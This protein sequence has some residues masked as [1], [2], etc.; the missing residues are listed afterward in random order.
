MNNI[1]K[2]F[3]T[4]AILTF[5]YGVYFWG[6]PAAINIEKRID[7]FEKYLKDSTGYNISV[8]KP[9]IKMGLLP[10]VWFMAEDV[11]LLNNDKSKVFNMTHSAIKLNLLPLIFGKIQVANFSAD[12]I[13]AD[14]IYT[15]NSELKLGQYPLHKLPSSKMTLSKAYFRIGNY[16]IK[17][18][19]LKQNKQI[20][21]NG[22]YFNLDEFKRNKRIKLSTSSVLS[23]GNKNSQLMA[24]IDIK[25]P[26][27]KITEDQFK[28]KGTINNLDLSDFSDYAK[29]I[30]NSNITSLSGIIN[31]ITDTT[32]K[33]DKHKNIFTKLTIENLK[34]IQKETARSIYC[35]NKIEIKTDIDTIKNGLNIRNMKILSNGIDISLFGKAT[36]LESKTPYVDFNISINNSR[37]EKFIPLL[38]GEENLIEEVNFY[39]LKKNL[40]YGDINGNLKVKGKFNTPDINGKILV[41]EGYL[42]KPL[43]NNTEKAVIKLTFKDTKMYMDVIV[44]ASLKETVWVK[45]NVDLYGNKYADLYIKSTKNVDLNIAETVLNPLH[46]ILKF[47]LGPVPIMDIQGKGDIN[48]HVT[49]NRK[50]PHAW[51]TFNFRETTASFLDIKNMTLKNGE[52]KL[53]FDDQNTFFKTKKAF[54]NNKPVEVSGNCTLKGI[55][56]FK[57]SAKQQNLGDLLKIIKTSPM[58]IDIQKLLQPVTAAKGLT[59]ISINLTGTVIDVNNVVFNKNIF[60]KGTLDLYSNTVVL[61]GIPLSNVKGKINFNNL[62]TYFDL[63]SD[64]KNSQIKINGKADDKN[65]DVKIISD[66][67]VLKDAIDILKL[68]IPFKE[69]I[70]Q[71]NTSFYIRYNGNINKIN[72]EKLNAQGKIYQSYGKNISINNA[73]FNIN[74]GN[75]KISTLKGKFKNTPYFINLYATKILTP[76]QSINGSF[77]LNEFNLSNLNELRPYFPNIFK[78]INNLDGKIKLNGYIKNNEIYADTV[79]NN[80]NLTYIPENLPLK[81]LNG[82]IQLKKNDV[83]LANI[84]TLIGQMPFFVNGKIYNFNTKPL[85]N[86]YINAKPTQEFIDQ[87]FNKKAVYPLKIK[88]DINLSSTISGSLNALKNK[89]I[90]KLSENASIYY[91]GATLGSILSN[92]NQTPV[93]ITIDNIIYQNGIRINNFQ[94]NKLIYSQNGKLYPKPQLSASGNINILKNNDLKFTNFKIKTEEATDA[95]IFNI[96]FRKPLMKQGVFTSD[97]TLNGKASAPI[98]FGKLNINSIDMPLFDATIKDINFDFRKDMLYLNAG[99]AVLTN[100]LNIWAAMQN[101]PN[102]PFIFENIKVNLENLDLNKITTALRDYDADVSRNLTATSVQNNNL[103]LSN[104][105]IKKSEL[106]AQNIKIKNLNATN[107][108]SN[109]TLNNKMILDV[110]NYKFNVAEGTVKGN[111]KYNLL[112]NNVKLEMNVDNA[113]A[114]SIAETLF[115][116][117]GQIYGSINGNVTLFCNGSSQDNCTK[118]LGGNGKFIVAN[119]KM[120]KLGSLEYLLKAGNL[121][122]GGLTGLSING[123]IDLITPYKTGD[124]D[125]ISGN[126]HIKNGIAD[127]IQIFSAGKDLNMYM[128]GSYNF[129]NLIADLQ[130]FGALTKNFSTLFGKIGNASLNTLFN[131]IPGINVSEAPSVVTEDIK[132]IPNSAENTA[133]VFNAEIYG[134]INGD[135]YVKSF[136]W[137]K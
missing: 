57:I 77:G 133:R 48:L 37:T 14:F 79:L 6:I 94:Y 38:P 26:I 121:V 110:N 87:F 105:I 66:K 17:L 112:S 62:N 106:S 56:D 97:I 49:G 2:S 58:L 88:G 127:D 126:F 13:T 34:I 35:N 80:I 9:H 71:I 81:I 31:L 134:D 131:T 135:D 7:F 83:V 116:L 111:I 11:S 74:N 21:L 10:A 92:T 72:S 114:Q 33:N 28:I 64:L 93:D 51:G 82:K 100:N 16:Q 137:V 19:D 76:Q 68:R 101:N 18:N 3:I 128:K 115:D 24:D 20:L 89:T 5:F 61:Q 90:L 63:K 124:F 32:T 132:K 113:N 55:L 84:N 47:D 36:K 99:G 60:A 70:G 123:I 122:K 23:I 27:N 108:Y 125:S 45:G 102:P 25:L 40:F 96:I 91:M 65:A 104:I 130:I 67:F 129:T 53:L 39:A 117:K 59:D 42:N 98:I 12:K 75:F 107:F 52:G 4:I 78:I 136:K 50:D 69:D 8:E 95:K 15:K 46:E 103:D 22:N 86:L 118:S 30:P 44:P 29:A 120:P 43:P 85:L 109:I 119:G 54:L 1:R 73:D 41:K